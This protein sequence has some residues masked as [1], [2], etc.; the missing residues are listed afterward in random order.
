MFDVRRMVPGRVAMSWRMVRP[1]SGS[2]A[3]T[4]LPASAAAVVAAAWA[5]TNA[6]SRRALGA[7]A[8]VAGT[9]AV[10]ASMWTLAA[11]A[12]AGLGL[13]VGAGAGTGI[14]QRGD[15]GDGRLRHRQI[16]RVDGRG[17]RAHRGAATG[18]LRRPVGRRPVRPGARRGRDLVERAGGP[19]GAA[20][21]QAVLDVVE[22]PGERVPELGVVVGRAHAPDGGA[23]EGVVGRLVEEGHRQR[24]SSHSTRRSR[25]RAR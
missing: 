1:A 9:A 12:G 10:G 3:R 21:A 17:H 13:G 18:M 2:T 25:V 23:D 8:A 19:D 6:R 20:Q 16:D 15:R 4:P 11:W 24:T 5:E 7:A 22:V 14:E